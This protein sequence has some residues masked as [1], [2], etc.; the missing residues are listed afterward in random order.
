MYHHI[1]NENSR[2]SKFKGLNVEE[3]KAQIKYLK[4]N[5]NPIRMEDV[6]NYYMN[7][8]N[9]LPRNAALLT[10]DDNYK[11]HYDIV[12][13]ILDEEG[14]Q[15]SFFVPTITLQK[16][17]V[18][19]VHKIH[20]LLI[21]A[22][23]KRLYLDLLG[24]VNEHRKEYSLPSNNDYTKRFENGLIKNTSRFDT[25]G[26]IF[27]KRMLQTELPRQLRGIIIDELFQKYIKDDQKIIANEL[28]MN[29]NQL[30]FMNRKG[31]Y[32]GPHGHNHYWLSELNRKEQKEEINMSIKIMNEIGFCFNSWAMSY[33]NGD[34]NKSLLSYL[35]KKGC[36]V[37][38]IDDT[39][40]ISDL[41]NNY[42]LTLP[43]IDAKDVSKEMNKNV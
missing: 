37:G 26:V 23:L 1:N 9:K 12:F 19:D 25:K 13:P 20:L 5:Y 2:Y 29:I 32:I 39:P 33:P 21:N 38:M 18:L 22:D 27:I 11:E 43:R 40:L 15:G 31:M 28:Y 4:K 3:F 42:H 24:R 8:E 36:K 10:F 35:T 34:Y 14:V 41:V 7:R 17:M 16:P 6:F 30:K